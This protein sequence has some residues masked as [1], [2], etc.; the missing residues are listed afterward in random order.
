[1][2]NALDKIKYFLKKIQNAEESTRRFWLIV[3][4]A[5]AM[6]MVL[7]LWLIYMKATV[8]KVE[9]PRNDS[10]LAADSVSKPGIGKIFAAGFKN[11]TAQIKE[12]ISSR[13]QFN[14]EKRERN[15]IL[16]KIEKIPKTKLP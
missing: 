4:S 15:F 13:N 8:A 6:M 11:L 2:N 3:F 7:G 10:E 5:G 1:M 12:K 9:G 16:E 14:F